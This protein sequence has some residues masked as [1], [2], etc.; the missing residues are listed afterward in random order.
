MTAMKVVK[1]SVAPE[2]SNQPDPALFH[3]AGTDSS[4]WTRGTET[5]GVLV[6]PHWYYLSLSLSFSLSVT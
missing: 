5:T 3:S 2:L 6:G 1:S 4:Y